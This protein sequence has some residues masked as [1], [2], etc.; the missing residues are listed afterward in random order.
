MIELTSFAGNCEHV[1]QGV[2]LRPNILCPKEQRHLVRVRDPDRLDQMRQYDLVH[3]NPTVEVIVEHK[4]NAEPGYAAKLRLTWYCRPGWIEKSLTAIVP[5][6]LLSVLNYI[7]SVTFDEVE[8]GPGWT[9]PYYN[10]CAMISLA[11]VAVLG[12]TF[13][14]ASFTHSVQLGHLHDIMLLMG[15][16]SSVIA[17][18]DWIDGFDF[19]LVA[20]KYLSNAFMFGSFLIP[21]LSCVRVWFILRRIRSGRQPDGSSFLEQSCGQVS[22]S[23]CDYEDLL[24]FFGMEEKE[25]GNRKDED[26]EEKE[27]EIKYEMA[28]TRNPKLATAWRFNRKRKAFSIGMVRQD[29]VELGRIRSLP[30]LIRNKDVDAEG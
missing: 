14:N 1:G 24:A 26:K 10:N 29:V 27:K 5:C 16:S 18:I 28:I 17:G 3:P 21:L 2:E 8:F 30:Q 9:E 12:L 11:L 22:G 7:N 15:L 19:R 4:G 25:K 23:D 13:S 6:L 20:G